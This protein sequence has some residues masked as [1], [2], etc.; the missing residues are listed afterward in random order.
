MG[1]KLCYLVSVALLLVTT[2]CFGASTDYKVT[3]DGVV[4]AYDNIMK[5]GPWVD[6]RSYASLSAAVTAISTTKRTVAISTELTVTADLSIPSNITLLVFQ[7]GKLTVSTSMTLTINSTIIAGPYQ[8]FAGAG[9]VKFAGLCKDSYPEWWGAVRDG[10]TNDVT[11]IQKAIDAFK[12]DLPGV[13]HLSAGSYLI[14]AAITIG[15]DNENVTLQG[16]GTGESIIYIKHATAHGIDISGSST[17]PVRPDKIEVRDLQVTR[18]TYTDPAADAYGIKVYY[19]S[20]VRLDH[21]VLYNHRVGVYSEGTTFS[22]YKD[23]SIGG[24]AIGANENYGFFLASDTNG[25]NSLRLESCLVYYRWTGFFVYG[26]IVADLFMINNETDFCKTGVYIESTEATNNGDIQLI[27]QV[28]DSCYA[29]GIS[30]VSVSATNIVGGWNHVTVSD[31][32]VTTYSISVSGSSGVNISGVT[33]NGSGNPGYNRGVYVNASSGTVI[34][35]SSFRDNEYGV[36]LNTADNCLVNGNTFYSPTGNAATDHIALTGTSNSNVVSN[37][38]LYGYATDGVDYANANA[39]YNLIH[40]NMIISGNITNKINN[41][42]AG[43][44][45]VEADNKTS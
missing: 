16:M 23:I 42:G 44:G 40:G 18:T 17:G 34:S 35:S 20:N 41:T 21:I 6:P 28:N 7:G 3:N 13:V 12:T 43:T 26:K 39:T 27:N 32:A 37:N 15:V 22:I 38:I 8:I 25:N 2:L 30:L 33:L 36:V 11:Y 45:N 1:Q 24:A 9:T 4:Y 31:P 19:A 5:S 29:A 14:E 10:T